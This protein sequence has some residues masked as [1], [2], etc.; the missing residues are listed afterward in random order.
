MI[1]PA[2]LRQLF[3]SGQPRPVVT[4]DLDGTLLEDETHYGKACC[5]ALSQMAGISY[6]EAYAKMCEAYYRTGNGI[7]GLVGVLPGWTNEL[8]SEC[9]RRASEVYLASLE[10]HLPPQIPTLEKLAKLATKTSALC[11]LTAN[12]KHHAEHVLHVTTLRPLFHDSLVLGSDCTQGHSKLTVE[13]YQI[14]NGR[15]TDALPHLPE[16]TPHVMVEDVAAN[17]P[18]AKRAEIYTV[19]MGAKP[20]N[21]HAAAVDFKFDTLHDVLDE[22]NGVRP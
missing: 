21:G 17:L 1:T 5:D 10:H 9:G 12:R 4:F 8:A 16:G 19:H 18:A 6:E 11:V 15:I 13:S 14:L 2:R 20:L 3:Q 7:K 22:M